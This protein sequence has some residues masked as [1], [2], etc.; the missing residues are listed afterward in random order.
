MAEIY[1]KHRK[2]KRLYASVYR[3]VM[4]EQNMHI[5]SDQIV[6]AVNEIMIR[7]DIDTIGMCASMKMYDTNKLSKV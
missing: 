4:R 1:L 3:Y 7:F 2:D 5:C 6:C